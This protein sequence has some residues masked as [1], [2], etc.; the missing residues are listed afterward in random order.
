MLLM[1]DKDRGSSRLK[2]KLSLVGFYVQS[3]WCCGKHLV[4][5]FAINLISIVSQLLHY[6]ALGF[7]KH[8][9]RLVGQYILIWREQYIAGVVFVVSDPLMVKS[10]GILL[11]IKHSLQLELF[12]GLRVLAANLWV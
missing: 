2:F 3:L 6:A 8:D 4:V 5:L 9:V 1:V 12:D 10:L 11:I 7:H